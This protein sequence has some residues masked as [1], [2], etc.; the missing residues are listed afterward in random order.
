ELFFRSGNWSLYLN[1]HR[2]GQ[3]R[4][5]R[6]WLGESAGAGSVLAARGPPVAGD[7]VT[8]TPGAAT[9]SREGQTARGEQTVLLALFVWGELAGCN[10][11]EG[12]P[13]CFH[14]HMGVRYASGF[15]RSETINRIIGPLPLR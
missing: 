8:A 14:P 11:V 5:H 12:A 1:H 15:A 4:K 3:S 9:G 2:A 6:T 7:L 10:P 13:L